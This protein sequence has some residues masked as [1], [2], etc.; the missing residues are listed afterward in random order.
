MFDPL[1]AG[2]PD[3]VSM[4]IHTA[5]DRALPNDP[6]TAYTRVTAAARNLEARSSGGALVGD[7]LGAALDAARGDA[8][9]ARILFLFLGLPAAVL[10]VLLTATVVDSGSDRRRREQALLRARGASSTQLLRLS[11][12]EALLVGVLG[13]ALGVAVAA[14]VGIAAFG[15]SSFGANP[16]A[17]LASAGASAAV[18]L[19]IAGV[20]VLAPAWREQRQ[21]SVASARTWQRSI[22]QPLW[23][24]LVW[25]SCCSAPRECSSGSPGGVDIRSCS[26]P[27]ASRRS[28]CPTG[29]SSHPRCSGSAARC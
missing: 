10:A 24:R 21:A 5:L 18:G 4:Q 29:P 1:A 8:A 23:M 14:V 3:L 12:A 19:A 2:R 6:S 26:H 15:T 13:S 17:A 16:S 11:A 27:K 22:G 9:Y 7:N 20:T 25:T 28:R